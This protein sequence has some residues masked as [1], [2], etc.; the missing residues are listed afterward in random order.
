MG[1]LTETMSGMA[2]PGTD[3][4]QSSVD[5]ASDSYDSTEVKGGWRGLLRLV[6]LIHGEFS[7]VG[8]LAGGVGE[9]PDAVEGGAELGMGG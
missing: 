2:V 6:N 3:S 9:D 5:H 8:A 4:S 7:G 1:C